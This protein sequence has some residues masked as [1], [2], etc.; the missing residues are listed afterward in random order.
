MSLHRLPQPVIKGEITC[1][2]IAFLG[3]S[4]SGGVS[5]LP[6]SSIVVTTARALEQLNF[7]GSF[8]PVVAI[9]WTIIANDGVA[10]RA[11]ARRLIELPCWIK[12]HPHILH[13]HLLS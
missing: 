12:G 8:I 1:Q 2:S 13:C 3:N 4:D 5:L 10:L 7:Q 6:L 9:S 11:I